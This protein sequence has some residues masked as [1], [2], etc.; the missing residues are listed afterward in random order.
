MHSIGTS[1]AVTHPPDTAAIFRCVRLS[2]RAANQ[3]ICGFLGRLPF[4]P[5][6][7]GATQE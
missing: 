6:I 7:M 1:P 2:A 5:F 4:R 3:A